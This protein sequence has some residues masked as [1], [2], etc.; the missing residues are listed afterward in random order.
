MKQNQISKNEKIQLVFQALTI[1]A[2]VCFSLCSAV[3]VPQSDAIGSRLQSFAV[4]KEKE[5][6]SLAS[7]ADDRLPPEFQS[8]FSAIQNGNWQEASN[9]FVKIRLRADADTHRRTWFQPVLETYGAEEQL[10]CG[11]EKYFA[12]YANDVIQSIPRGSIYFG[13]TDPGRFIITAMQKSQM[14]GEPFFTVTQNTLSDGT[15]LDY[16]RSIYGDKIYVPSADDSQQCFNDYCADALARMRRGQLLPGEDITTDDTGKPQV[17]GQVAVMGMNGLLVKFIVDHNPG[18]QSYVEESFPLAWMYPYLEPHGLILKLGHEQ[19]DELSDDTVRHD[20]DYWVKTISP[21]I[22]DWLNNETSV[23]VVSSFAEKVFLRHD[24]SGFTGDTNFVQNACSYKMFSKARSSIAGL[25]AWR[26]QHAADAAERQRMSNEADFAFRQSLALCPFSPE[27]VFRYVQFLMQANRIDD[28]IIVARTCLSLDPNNESV[29]NL[30]TQLERFKEAS[31]ARFQAQT[32]VQEMEMKAQTD[33]SDYHNIFSLAGYY[34]QS[35]QTNRATELLNQTIS[36]PAV[37]AEVL[38]GA[39]QI[40]AQIKDFPDLETVLKKLT[41]AGPSPEAWYDLA[42]LQARTGENDEAIESLRTAIQLSDQRL[43]SNSGALDIRGAARNAP[44]FNS[45]SD[46][47][48]FQ[49]LVSP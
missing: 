25:Y 18:C 32:Q 12:A 20:H 37:P 31:A 43:Q 22:G 44:D 38:R 40:F 46:R 13:G 7:S 11:I 33:P 8:F 35:Q 5:A 26:Y 21:M 9:D 39:A 47:A 19:L 28:A 45:I 1:L 49:K 6:L 2:F 48:D 34:L 14:N 41:D 17:T 10:N 23:K 24:F 4:E 16:V 29:S 30:V 3:S 15:Y 42:R 27:A 36:R